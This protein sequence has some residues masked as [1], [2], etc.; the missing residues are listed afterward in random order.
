MANPLNITVE[1]PDELL[2]TGYFGVG[3]LVR[4]E[5][6][7]TGGGIGFSEVGTGAILTA[8]TLYPY[9]DA[10]GVAGDYY[11]VRYSKASPS[12][13]ADYSVYGEEFQGGV[14]SLICSLADARQRIGILSPTDHSQDEN[15]LQWINQVDNWLAMRTGRRFM[16]DPATGTKTYT[17]DVAGSDWWW[18]RTLYIPRG[19]RSVTLLE[20][21]PNTG[22]TY[23]TVTATN[24]FLRPSDG[25][26]PP[27]WPATRIELSDWG[28]A[29]F[30]GG[31]D[32]VRVTG[33]FGFAAVPPA[34]E[35][36]ALTLVVAAMRETATSGGETV[37]VN[38]D[39]SR[40]FERS[41]STRDRTTLE[42]YTDRPV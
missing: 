12:I 17:F 13:P 37:V 1:N 11:R 23:S 9:Y 21:A 14:D 39:G 34:I 36:L 15:L 33:T 10:G 6:S 32:T 38:I 40:T 25:E 2:N 5:R 28:S 8:T 27:G 24:V 3:A 19:V 7:S 30:R 16:P 41:L 35:Q 22:G 31:Y 18:S 29:Y 20:T 26:R 42:L 4:V